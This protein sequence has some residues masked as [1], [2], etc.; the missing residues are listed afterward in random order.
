MKHSPRQLL[1]AA[2]LACALA[3]TSFAVPQSKAGQGTRRKAAAGEARHRRDAREAVAA[4]RE[5]AELARGFDD[6][7]QSVDIQA[8]AADALWPHDEQAARAVLRRAWEAV[9]DPNAATKVEGVGVS[10]D[11]DEDRRET[12]GIARRA[13]ITA[14]AKHDARLAETFLQEFQRTA[15]ADDTSAV[16]TSA[17]TR[18][19]RLSAGAGERLS[20]AYRLLG[21]GD[22]KRAAELMAPVIE[23]VPR[24]VDPLVNFVASLRTHSARDADALYLRL[25]AR[26]RADASADANDVLSLSAPVVSPGFAVFLDDYGTP[27]FARVGNSSTSRGETPPAEIRRAFYETAAAVLLRAGTPEQPDAAAAQYFAA[28]RLLPFFEREAPQYAP[29]LHAR[30]TALAA[31]LDPA[32]RE[33]LSASME[34]RDLAAKNPVDP[35]AS[36]LSRLK[37]ARD[38]EARDSVRLGAVITASRR[39]LWERARTLAAEMEAA[40]AQRDARLVIAVHQLLRI[41]DSYDDEDAGAV[42]RAA[43]FARGADVP[44]EVRAAGL[45][46]AAELAARRGGRARADQLISEAAGHAAQAER[47]QGRRLTALALVALS[48]ARSASPRLWEVLPALV[49]A[50]NENE[51]FPSGALA[52]WFTLGPE[53]QR[54]EFAAPSEPFSL[55]DVFAAAAPLDAAKAFGEARR[56]EDEETRARALVEAARAV[57]RPTQKTAGAR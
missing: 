35:I 10:E 11:P 18:R 53:K 33:R 54:T 50:D 2:A 8:R 43:D 34:V 41:S 15:E 21:D 20:L 45:A 26:V 36:Q 56:L 25:L 1:T 27:S 40:E 22:A 4:L 55:A 12:V 3:Q 28:G 39:T 31:S 44:P 19:G 9:N 29:Q 38:A 49:R 16:S 5:A 46:Q 37:D 13:V 24:P 51:D 14:A 23:A 32:R 48:A 6:L 17:K 57:L 52:F 42:E 30:M 7:Y 47:E